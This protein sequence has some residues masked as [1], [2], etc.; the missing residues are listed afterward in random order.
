M[1]RG[2]P[3]FGGAGAGGGGSGPALPTFIGSTSGTNSSLVT[4]TL[5]NLSPGTIQAGDLLLCCASHG[6]STP[7]SPQGWNALLPVQIEQ[8][9]GVSWRQY[10]FW[11]IA[12]GF[13]P[14]TYSFGG[15][16][17]VALLIDFRG[18]G[19]FSS[20]PV[21]TDHGVAS[22]NPVI[23][24][25]TTRFAN[26][27]VIGTIALNP[28]ALTAPSGYTQIANIAAVGGTNNALYVGYQ[29]VPT[30]GLVASQA[31]VAT[32]GNWSSMAFAIGQ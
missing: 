19:Q 1:P 2:W 13:E 6:S 26:Q 7:S 8:L 9:N 20:L 14:T 3:Q 15:S 5:A 31:G 18:A 30:A 21:I 29:N 17:S 11:R 16:D 32:S 27:V 22:A 24:A 10:W 4:L 12:D 28:N 25:I 23:P